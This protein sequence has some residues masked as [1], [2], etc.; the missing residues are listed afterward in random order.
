MENFIFCAVLQ[1]FYTIHLINLNNIVLFCGDM[2]KIQEGITVELFS[3]VSMFFL[4]LGISFE[5]VL[6]INTVLYLI[7]GGL[8]KWNQVRIFQNFMKLGGEFVWVYSLIVII[9]NCIWGKFLSKKGTLSLQLRT[10][11]PPSSF[12][13]KSWFP[14]FCPPLHFWKFCLLPFSLTPSPKCKKTLPLLK[15]SNFCC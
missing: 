10:E 5:N 7:L 8:I 12:F 14:L 11:E 15:L 4:T 1:F 9:I 2:F 6:N 3:T 13:K